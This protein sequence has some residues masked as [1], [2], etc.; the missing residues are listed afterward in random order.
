ME[1]LHET[2]GGWSADDAEKAKIVCKQRSLAVALGM[3]K[4]LQQWEK[5]RVVCDEADGLAACAMKGRDSSTVP[6]KATPEDD[7]PTDASTEVRETKEAV[8]RVDIV[9][10]HLRSL[11][12]DFE[13]RVIG[14]SLFYDGSDVDVVATGSAESLEAAYAR[15]KEATCFSAMF[16]VVNGKDPA[17]LRG[18]IDGIPTDIQFARVGGDTNA[19]DMTW[20]AIYV[21]ETLGREFS[22]HFACMRNMHE[23]FDAMDLKGHIRA[24]YPA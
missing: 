9:T 13:W 1:Y 21:G 12:P 10:T 14:S 6:Q 15:L 18:S 17:I 11:V 19:E 2:M 24:S 16:D 3:E 8:S 20:N 4:D 22:G 23:W 5:L 7:C